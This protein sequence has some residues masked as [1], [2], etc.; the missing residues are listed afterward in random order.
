MPAAPPCG[1]GPVRQPRT[2]PPGAKKN[3]A[4]P[5]VASH[6]RIRTKEAS[7]FELTPE[8]RQELTGP[9]PARAVDP[10]TNR[11]YVLVAA[12]QY[13]RIKGLLEGAFDIRDAYALMD[14]VADKE[15]WNDPEMDSYNIY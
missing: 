7:M 4:S 11:T 10:E 3:G 1:G 15:G 13:E 5:A 14:Q 2:C 9:E 8:Q 12:E 6:G